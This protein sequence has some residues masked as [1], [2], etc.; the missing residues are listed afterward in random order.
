MKL[1]G[2]INWLICSNCG[3][4]YTDFLHNITLQCSEGN[5]KLIKCK[6]CDPINRRYE[7]NH[8]IITPTFLKSLNTLQLKNIWHNAFMDLS[9]ATNIYFV[10]YSF[11]DA[12]FELRYL[13]KKALR[14]DAKIKVIL[15]DLDNPDEYKKYF[16]AKCPQKNK[17]NVEN[18]L[19]L[20]CKRY[21]TFFNNHDIEFYYGG[22]EKAFTEKFIN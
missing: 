20:P 14:P 13:L 3:R 4:L 18:R 15:H 16:K 11:P 22:I 5:N 19:N 17:T 9:E 21:E 1:H 10:G 2:S 8:I 6:F 12:D 7:L